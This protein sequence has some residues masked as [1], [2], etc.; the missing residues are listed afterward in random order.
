MDDNFQY[1]TALEEQGSESMLQTQWNVIIFQV[2]TNQ[3]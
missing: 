1:K 2:L 3:T